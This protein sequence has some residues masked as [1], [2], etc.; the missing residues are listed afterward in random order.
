[1]DIGTLLNLNHAHVAR[2]RLATGSGLGQ[3]WSGLLL[4]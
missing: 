2:G 1:M 3:N 4:A